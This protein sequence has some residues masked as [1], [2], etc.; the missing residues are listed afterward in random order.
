MII[1]S[2]VSFKEAI[3]GAGAIK[4]GEIGLRVISIDDLIKMKKG[5]GRRID[6]FDIKELR[7]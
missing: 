3:K 1:E 4:V 7:K 2:P 5:T 6:E